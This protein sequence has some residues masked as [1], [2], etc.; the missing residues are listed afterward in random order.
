MK[1]YPIEK[2]KYYHSKR[3]NEVIAVSTY[4]GKVVKGKAKCNS[5]DEFDFETGKKLAAARLSA[6]VSRLRKQ[7]ASRLWL[8]AQRQLM[9]AQRYFNKMERYFYDA[10]DEVKYTEAQLNEIEKTLKGE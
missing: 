7:N 9:E 3:T 4:A 1:D 10:C 2:Y 8:R 6:R 5:A